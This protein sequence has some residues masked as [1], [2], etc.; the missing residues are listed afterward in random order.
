MVCTQNRNNNFFLDLRIPVLLWCFGVKDRVQQVLR[1]ETSIF[2]RCFLPSFATLFQPLLF[3]R[4]LFLSEAF[5]SFSCTLVERKTVYNGAD[6]W[7]KRS[8]SSFF[9][10][11]F[12]SFF[13]LSSLVSLGNSH[14]IIGL[15]V[16]SRMCI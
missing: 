12:I 11:L 14:G 7:S 5:P 10:Y 13:Y 3:P 16:I 6:E 4:F 1:S 15:K 8:F 2:S 9:L